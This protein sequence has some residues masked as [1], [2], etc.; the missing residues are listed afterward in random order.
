MGV[1]GM[2][3]LDRVL[4]LMGYQTNQLQQQ[5]II[6]VYQ[7]YRRVAGALAGVVV[8]GTFVW[9]MVGALALAGIV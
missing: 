7:P 4:L 1:D 2:G 8:L 9:I 5:Q 3:T 6:Q